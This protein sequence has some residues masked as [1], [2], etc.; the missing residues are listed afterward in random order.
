MNVRVQFFHSKKPTK[1][2]RIPKREPGYV[3]VV[4]DRRVNGK[5]PIEPLHTFGHF[6]FEALVRA[7]QYRLNCEL[8]MNLRRKAVTR[9]DQQMVYNLFVGQLGAATLE[10]IFDGPLDKAKNLQPRPVKAIS[11]ATHSLRFDKPK[12]I[13]MVPKR[14][15]KRSA[16]E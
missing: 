5:G 10:K 12:E 7:E 15:R 14:K 4:L 16:P 2:R 8:A 11:K 6:S 13:W 9:E 1:S 3:T